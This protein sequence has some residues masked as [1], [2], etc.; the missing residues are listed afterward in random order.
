[1]CKEHKNT[2]CFLNRKRL[3]I[4]YANSNTA[5]FDLL[6]KQTIQFDLKEEYYNTDLHIGAYALPEFVK[7]ARDY[8]E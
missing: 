6:R 8:N 3:S 7:E 2:W 1:M 5:Y 4:S